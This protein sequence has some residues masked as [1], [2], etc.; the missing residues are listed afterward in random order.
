[1]GRLFHEHRQDVVTDALNALDVT[2]EDAE[3]LDVGCGAGGWL[4]MLVELGARPEHLTGMDISE[5]RIRAAIRANPAIHWQVIEGGAIPA[6]GGRFDLV[7]QS[8]VFSSILDDALATELAREM[9]RVLKPGG[10]V[11]WV[12][13]LTNCPGR[14]RAYPSAKVRQLLAG[15]DIAYERR[16]YPAYLRRL[17]RHAWLC[18]LLLRWSDV[19]SECLIVVLRKRG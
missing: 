9:V 3:V 5:S 10:L 12:D 8:M 14:L 11:L 4:R 1:M 15:C 13:L 16:A 17:Y 2:L 7:M 19:G 18:R 6:A